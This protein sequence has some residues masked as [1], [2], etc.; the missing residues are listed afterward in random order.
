M[1]VLVRRI[2]GLAQ[3]GTSR[4]ASLVHCARSTRGSDDD[5]DT[6]GRRTCA[7]RL[8]T[9]IDVRYCRG[10]VIHPYIMFVRAGGM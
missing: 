6:T 2:V 10:R 8:R 5:F 3:R 9:M 1:E 4:S 7:A